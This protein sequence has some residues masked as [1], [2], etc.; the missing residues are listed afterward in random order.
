MKNK[1]IV[2]LS[3]TVICLFSALSGT[4]Y[5]MLTRRFYGYLA[6]DYIFFGPSLMAI[7]AAAAVWLILES[8]FGTEVKLPK[9]YIDLFIT[10][11][12]LCV[13]WVWG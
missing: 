1:K 12:T 6:A 7:A 11:I 4:L 8:L 9:I 2:A 3:I 5:I 10:L 13:F